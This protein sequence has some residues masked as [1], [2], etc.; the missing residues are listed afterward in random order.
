MMAYLLLIPLAFLHFWLRKPFQRL[1]LHVDTGFYVANATIADRKIRLSEGWNARFAG[2]SKVIPEL[3]YSLVFLKAGPEGYAAKSR[4]WYSVYALLAAAS[5]GLLA[6]TVYAGAAWVLV[7]ATAI[8]VLYAAEHQYGVYYESGEQ[9]E[10]LF[11]AAGTACLVMGVQTGAPGWFIAGSCI[12]CFEAVFIKLSSVITCGLLLAAMAV[13]SPR[14]IAHLA[15]GPVV[16]GIVYV[17]WLTLLGRSVARMITALWHHERFCGQRMTPYVFQ[18]RIRAKL[19]QLVGQFAAQPV[20]PMLALLG[21]ATMRWSMPQLVIAVYLGACLVTFLF[22]ASNMWYYAIPLQVPLAVFAAGGAGFLIG[23]G[24]AGWVTLALAG[25]YWLYRSNLL[26]RKQ[27]RSV[28]RPC[29]TNTAHRAVAHSIAPAG[30]DAS[31]YKRRDT[32]LENI[33]GQLR[34][35]VAGEPFLVYGM[36]NQAYVLAGSSYKT[37]LVSPWLWLDQMHNAWQPELSTQLLEA[38]PKWILDTD[39]CFDA[40]AT[41]TGLRLDYELV[42]DWPGDF[43]LYKLMQADATG[44]VETRTF[45][46][47]TAGRIEVERFRKAL[48]ERQAAGTTLRDWVLIAEAELLRSALDAVERVGV[49]APTTFDAASQ[50]NGQVDGTT[51]VAIVAHP[52]SASDIRIALEKQCQPNWLFVPSR[53]Q[54][55]DGQTRQSETM[56]SVLADLAESG[57][58]RVAVYG[59]GAHTIRVAD[60]VRSAPVEVVAV[61][62]DNP[63]CHGGRLMD[64]PIKPLESAAELGVDAVVVSSD[65]YEAQMMR[66]CRSLSEAGI[67]V[68]GLYQSTGQAND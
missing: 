5:V 16:V 34:H 17:V 20:I 19:R 67:D 31:R 33:A 15:V 55:D 12:W 41:R 11:Q 56:A 26:L 37:S 27:K 68:V 49:A 7:P 52:Q 2:A 48:R 25:S 23:A 47:Q 35:R 36:M 54:P 66:R 28:G 14:H 59:A 60:A 53:P 43:L 40:Q 58:R 8:Y 44:D 10:V 30:G 22:Q 1:P 6:C 9:F 62:D 32:Q 45:A 63:A 65:T 29:P 64:W 13:A 57:K 46:P 50:P 24:P 61:L 39:H 3:F 51:P 21:L 38:P 18:A 4:Q 42:E